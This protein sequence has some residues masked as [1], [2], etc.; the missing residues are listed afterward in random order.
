IYLSASAERIYTGCGT[1]FRASKEPALDM[2]Y[3]TTLK[4]AGTMQ[5]LIESAAIKRVALI[6][7]VPTYYSPLPGQPQ[8]D[9]NRV[10]PFESDYLNPVGQY[11]LQDFQ[12]ASKPFKAHGKWVFFNAPSTALYVVV[13][14]DRSSG[15]LNDFAVQTFSMTTPEPCG[16]SFASTSADVIFEG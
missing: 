2:R 13:Q 16:A 9:D 7:N 15:I 4:G 10:L 12:A 14:A 11:A 5:S 6:Q 1:V 8:L 3:V